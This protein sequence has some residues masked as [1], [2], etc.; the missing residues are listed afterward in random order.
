MEF[1]M[2]FVLRMITKLDWKVFVNAAIQVCFYLC[3]HTKNYILYNIIDMT[4]AF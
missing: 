2:E 3:I 1:N 4:F